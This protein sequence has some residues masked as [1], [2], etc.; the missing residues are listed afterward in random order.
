MK[1][2]LYKLQRN[3]TFWVLILTVTGLSALLHYLIITGWWQMSGTV[4]DG[5]GL[6]EL[7][8]LSAF[9]VPLFFN[10]IISPLAAFYIAIEFSQTGVIKNQVM[11]GK[12]RSQIY[13]SKL[14][15]LTLGSIVVTVLLP[16]VVGIVEALL[17]GQV[18]I[19]NQVSIVY[20]L[21]AYLL[22]TLQFLGYVAILL[23]IAVIVGDSGKTIIFSILLT[24]IMFAIEKLPKAP[25]IAMLYENSIFHQFSAVFKQSMTDGEIMQSIL[26]ALISFIFITFCGILL[27]NK[28]EI[29]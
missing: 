3:S 5:A 27:F 8:A 19:L 4:F 17:V 11:S 24:I 18:D 15:V 23:L 16:V 26:I 7:N 14:L 28:K 20:L 2:E 29:K 6:S 1:A 13:L 9:T 25:I 12:K 10:L 21:R 22:F